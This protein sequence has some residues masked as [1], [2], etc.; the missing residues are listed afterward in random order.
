MIDIHADQ[1]STKMSITSDMN[2]CWISFI[3]IQMEPIIDL[4]ERRWGLQVTDLSPMEGYDSTNYK[5]SCVD[6]SFV[7]KSYS[8]ER[9]SYET[10]AAEN[11]VL[12]RRIQR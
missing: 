11:E 1:F 7:L 10:V 2:S 8:Y 12:H 3:Y 6:K 5:V 9:E 4:L